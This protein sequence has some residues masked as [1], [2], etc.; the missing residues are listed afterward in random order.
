MVNGSRC[1]IAI[2]WGVTKEAN[3]KATNDPYTRAEQRDQPPTE[4]DSYARSSF[5]WRRMQPWRIW[6][7]LIA[8]V[9]LAVLGIVWVT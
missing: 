2:R 9:V 5:T 1:L 3:M 7:L 4:K 6:T 8:A